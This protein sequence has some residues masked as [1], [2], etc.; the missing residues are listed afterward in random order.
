M[1]VYFLVF[2]LDFPNSQYNYANY[3]SKAKFEVHDEKVH[4]LQFP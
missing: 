1:K 3:K 4:E 2:G